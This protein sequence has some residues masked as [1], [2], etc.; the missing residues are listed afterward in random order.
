MTQDRL[1]GTAAALTV[2]LAVSAFALSMVAGSVNASYA[3]SMLL[4][5]AYVVMAGGFA[6]AAASGR[7]V[8]ARAGTGFAILYAG[9][10]T[11]VYFVQLTTVL[12][13][14]ASPDIL[15]ALSY[16]QLGSVMFNLELLGYALMALS[17]LFAGLTIAPVNR[18]GRWLKWMLMAHGVFAPV[19]LALPM[20]NVFGA[21]PRASGDSVGVA[22]AFGWCVYF[23]P[24]AL[25]AF[26]HLR[27]LNG[28]PPAE[29]ARSLSAS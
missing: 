7:H 15:R 24:V 8:A 21:M 27:S 9:T 6:Q 1:I 22:I 3:A 10:V 28:Q 23:L 12:H 11:A 2:A 13:G 20:M 16:Q 19:C 29:P 14:T 26:V 25:L 17:T 5:W 18:A 4:A